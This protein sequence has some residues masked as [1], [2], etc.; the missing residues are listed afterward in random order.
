MHY[1]LIGSASPPRSHRRRANASDGAAGREVGYPGSLMRS[2]RRRV[3]QPE[4]LDSLPPA[5]ARTSLADL[6]RLNRMFGGYS[7]LGHLL[8]DAGVPRT[9]PFSLLDIGAASG[10]MGAEIRR[11]NPHAHVMSTDLLHSH[12]TGDGPRVAA[13][14]FQLPFRPNAFDYAFSSL[15]LHHFSDDHVIELLAAMNRVARR[16]VL[17]VDLHRRWLPYW[18]TP[19][20][21]HILG[22]DPVTVHDAGLSV[23]AGFRPDELHQLASRAGL[24]NVRVRSRGLSY[25]LTLISH[26]MHYVN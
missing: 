10:D 4:L 5:R 18:F 16:G 15:F 1:A 11:F 13:D 9:E 3:I 7:A 23:A 2:L 22:W 17:A 12:L 8:R 19:V 6:V 25:R 21:E 26:K 20:T 24:E 14:A